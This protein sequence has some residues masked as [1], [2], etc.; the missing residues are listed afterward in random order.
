MEEGVNLSSQYVDTRLVQRDDLRLRKKSNTCLE[1]ELAAMGDMERKQSSLGWSQIFENSAGSQP[2]RSVL[3]LGNAGTGKTALIW[4]LGLKWSTGS[5]PQFDF[6]FLLDGKGLALINPAFSLQTLLLGG[7]SPETPPCLNIDLVF[8]RVAAAPERVLVVFDG[9]QET[10]HLEHLMQALEKDLVADLQM[11]NRKQAF[12]VR[13]LYSALLQRV[14]L[15]GC[16]LLIAARPRG[17]TGHLCRWADSLL[18]VCGFS[19]AEVEGALH[20]Y[21]TKPAD[22]ATALTRLESSP[23]LFS[24]C[25][26]PALFRL[27]CLVLEHSEHSE[28]LPDT[29]SGLCHRALRLKLT[30]EFKDTTG[31]RTLWSTRSHGKLISDALLGGLRRV[32]QRPQKEEFNLVQRFS[33]GTLFLSPGNRSVS[34]D[35][36]VSKQAALVKYLE[37]VLGHG[38]LSSA[39]LLDVCHYIYESGVGSG[40]RLL[41]GVLDTIFLR[42]M[43]FQGVRMWPSDVY[44]LGKVLEQVGTGGAGICLDLEDTGIQTSGILS[45]LGLSNIVTYRACTADVISLWEELEEKEEEL[46]LKAAMSKYKLNLKATQVCHVDNLAR[47]VSM[48]R[49]LMASQTDPVLALGVPVVKGIH[50]LELDLENSQLGDKGAGALAKVLVSLSDLEMLNLSQNDIGDRG[51]YDLSRVLMTPAKLRCLSLYSNMICD[52]GAQWLAKVLPLMVSLTNLDVKYNNLTDVGAQILA[53]SLKQCPSVKTLR[54][55][56]KCIPFGVFERLQKQD[57][58]IVCH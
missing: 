40:D 25:W 6:F 48:H 24:L 17:A 23:Y 57:S 58:R 47:L 15:P 34:K 12:T 43:R 45:L 16:T 10:R 41:A 27:V 32:R 56:N 21:F 44:V 20:R 2:K 42:E 3:V 26:N 36:V 35:T 37:E 39:P 29:L 52:S 19:P 5:F 9:F 28:T 53:A 31:S 51:V 14:L 46:H 22:H 54:M 7:L 33:I 50:K 4:N 1:K 49:R 30:Q 13:K 8:E 11:D 55:W 18:E 38:E